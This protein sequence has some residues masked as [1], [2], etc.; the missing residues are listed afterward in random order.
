MNID[1]QVGVKAEKRKTVINRTRSNIYLHKECSGTKITHGKFKSTTFSP[2]VN[3]RDF[4][5]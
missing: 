1:A 3:P 2:Q 4:R 5:G